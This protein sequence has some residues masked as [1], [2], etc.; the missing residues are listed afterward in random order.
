M[1]EVRLTE[2]QREA[3]ETLGRDICVVAGP[4]AGKTTVLIERF[5]SLVVSGISPL[6]I[7]AITFTEKA[8]TQLKRRLTEK[9]GDRPE[10]RP[11]IER[12]YVS[13]V[14]G[15]CARLLRENAIAAGI[16]PEFS[17]L[18]ERQA[19]L[20]ENQAVADAL[21][22]LLVEKPA[23]MRSL[24]THLASPDLGRAITDVYAAL[25]AAGLG[26]AD[27]AA[28]PQPAPVPFDAVLDAAAEFRARPTAARTLHQREAVGTLLEWCTHILELRGCPVSAR[29]FELLAAFKPNRLSDERLTRLKQDLIPAVTEG[30][31]TGFYAPDRQTL[32]EAIGRFDALYRQR[33]AAIG[34]LDFSDLEE[35]AVALLRDNGEVRA[36]TR[37]QFEQVLMDELQDTNRQQAHLIDL[38]RAPDR[39][40]AVGD[41]NQS[42]YGF[43]NADPAVFR[44]YRDQVASGGRPV[45]EL[46]ENFRSRAEI[47]CAA[48][49]ILDG[50]SG[51]ERHRLIPGKT[52]PAKTEPSVEIIAA[53]GRDSDEALEIEARLVARRIR[54]LE[55]S[56][57]L[58]KGLAGFQDFALLVRNSNTMPAFTAALQAEG[59][60]YQ[61]DR[62]RGFYHAQ[63]VFDLLALLGVLANPRDEISTAAVLRSPLVGISDETL[64]RLK[65]SGNLGDALGRLA[66]I[67]TSAFDAAD[68]DRLQRFASDLALWRADRYLV[69]ADRLLWRAIDRA[70]YDSHLAPRARANVD[71]LMGMLRQA[72]ERAPLDAVVAEFVRLREFDAGEP[73][74]A[75][76]DAGG[77]VQIMT[78][79]SAKG[80]EFPIVFLAALNKG[81]DQK[82]GP[83][84]FSPQLGLGARWRNPAGKHCGDALYTRIAAELHAKEAGE[85]ERLFYVAMTR[86]E[87]HLVLSF[88][89]TGN[90]HA[91]WARYLEPKLGLDL[92]SVENQPR[93]VQVHSPGG[94]PFVVRL[95]T[96][97]T[98]PELLTAGVPA[99]A[100][101]VG[102]RTSGS[103][104]ITGQHDSTASVTSI[105]Q[106]AACPRRY[107][108]G[109]Y[110]GWEGGP[111]AQIPDFA[112]DEI[113]HEKKEMYASQFG[114]HMHALLAG[115]ETVPAD[116]EA[117]ELVRRFHASPLGR[118]AAHSTR[119]EREFD[120]L[121]AVGD[122]VL[123]GQIDLWFEEAGRVILV[124]YKTDRVTAAAAAEHAEEYA[125]QLQLYAIALE[126]ALGRPVDEAYLYF[127]RPDLAVPVA[128]QPLFL[129]SA[130]TAVRD[131]LEAQERLE[132]PLNPGVRCR[133]CPF[134][135]GLC[136]A[137]TDI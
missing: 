25:R 101:T 36:R 120:F 3:V 51:V 28:F 118:R 48:L 137:N 129:H 125:L 18:D 111:P 5:L 126:R 12:A 105:S 133:R 102:E 63:E 43:R 69:P 14:H 127:L 85:G 50:A 87:E 83:V 90:A 47:L 74:A 115:L 130:E 122:V 134:F 109:G 75:L 16:D 58:E 61:V 80:L 56:L 34:A 20:L 121:L 33:K 41:I 106:F 94:L 132:F 114:R 116:P 40:Y 59:I 77:A 44:D 70:G 10:L 22:L 4:G 46:R 17:V 1:S 62:G 76:S 98:A 11:Q 91:E 82:P 119:A 89:S 19:P 108:L 9:F 23:A 2:R 21:D 135:R 100:A 52:F 99:V 84:C 29:H 67:D 124:D 96:A 65:Q 54:E 38:V 113:P 64:L 7:L 55:G 57:M 103:F 128:L 112:E 49:T 24:L 88:S 37:A 15:F 32:L 123:R 27:L 66:E 104:A 136:P 42:I 131:F 72:S 73:E 79:H 13:T 81:V 30:L 92:H 95:L 45:I 86:A 6:G 107:Y 39:F 68:L 110:L 31:I 60:P 71:K 93:V 53:T 8:T 78:I 26:V 35:F 117:A 97:D